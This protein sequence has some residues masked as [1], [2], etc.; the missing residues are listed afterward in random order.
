MSDAPLEIT[1]PA[2]MMTNLATQPVALTSDITVDAN[3][4]CRFNITDGNQPELGPNPG[5]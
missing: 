4:D 3:E 1:I 5:D 2:N